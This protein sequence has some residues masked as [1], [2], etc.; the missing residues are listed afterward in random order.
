MRLSQCARINRFFAL[1]LVLTIAHSSVRAADNTVAMTTAPLWS[2]QPTALV[3]AQE[4]TFQNGTVK[5]SGTL[6]SPNVEGRV[7]A[8]IFRPAGCLAR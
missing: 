4:R 8:V 7:P 1:T 3:E 2:A 6:Y 5:F